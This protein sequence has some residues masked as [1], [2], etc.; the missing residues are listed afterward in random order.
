MEDYKR[1]SI[2]VYINSLSNPQFHTIENVSTYLDII[3]GLSKYPI[4]SDSS[5]IHNKKQII[6]ENVRK[7][8][9]RKGSFSW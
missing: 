4:Y 5:F 9:V 3:K 6:G 1:K 8:S 7:I 2:I